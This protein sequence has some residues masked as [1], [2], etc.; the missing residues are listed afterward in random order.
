MRNGCQNEQDNNKNKVF[1]H[2]LTFYDVMDDE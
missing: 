2:G 1:L